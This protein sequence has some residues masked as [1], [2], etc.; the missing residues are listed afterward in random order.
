MVKEFD[1]WIELKA[2][3]HEKSDTRRPLFKAR[4]IWWCSLGCNVGEEEDGKNNYFDRPVLVL[5]KLTSNSFI[6]LPL[7]SAKKVG[8]WYVAVTFKNKISNV[9]LNQVRILDVKRCRDKFGHLDKEDFNR[10]VER[11]LELVTTP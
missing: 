3:L 7:T 5:K 9:M 10:V 4:D 2:Q 8:S 11:F 6:G 1:K